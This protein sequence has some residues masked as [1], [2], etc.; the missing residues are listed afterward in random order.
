MQWVV[1]ILILSW[2]FLIWAIRNWKLMIAIFA[3]AL[4]VQL[5]VAVWGVL[6]EL[7]QALA[8]PSRGVLI[9][10]SVACVLLVY[11]RWLVVKHRTAP[12][13]VLPDLTYQRLDA[14]PAA[15]TQRDF[16]GRM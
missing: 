7:Q 6:L 3:V 5:A 12:A 13:E 14:D 15:R 1:G 10:V 9:A 16:V 11:I 4:V 2:Y 8:L